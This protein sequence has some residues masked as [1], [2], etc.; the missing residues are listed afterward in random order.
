[1]RQ[2]WLQTR[3]VQVCVEN[4]H[5]LTTLLLFCFFQ[6]VVVQCTNGAM[7]RFLENV[8]AVP[9]TVEKQRYTVLL[10]VI[11]LLVLFLSFDNFTYKDKFAK[12]AFWIFQSII[13]LSATSWFLLSR[14]ILFKYMYVH[15][16]FPK[17][18]YNVYKFVIS[19]WPYFQ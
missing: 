11:G 8:R 15:I 1:M 17:A 14:L 6:C 3:N 12:V 13:L 18:T 4:P 19:C 5:M 9:K 7:I 10:K 2:L 16:E